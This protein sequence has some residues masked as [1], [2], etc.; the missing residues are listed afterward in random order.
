M[1]QVVINLLKNA[2][3]ASDGNPRI[4]LWIDV[5]PEA[6]TYLQVRDRG[7][8]MDSQ[9]QELDLLDRSRQEVRLQAAD[10][11]QQ[12]GQCG[13][14]QLHEGRSLLPVRR[15]RGFGRRQ[16]VVLR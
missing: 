15:A 1:Q 7:R 14:A 10:H 13:Q 5:N 6:G 8:S 4:S 2:E 3:E 16:R 12:L 9:R 11:R